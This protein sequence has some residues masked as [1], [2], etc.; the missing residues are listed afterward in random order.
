MGPHLLV[1]LTRLA[2]GPAFWMALEA[3]PIR[4]GSHASKE[5]FNFE[6][7]RLASKHMHEV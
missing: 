6:R 4:L 3:D 2:S 5:I 1:S 7:V